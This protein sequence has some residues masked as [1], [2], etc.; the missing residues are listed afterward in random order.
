MNVATAMLPREEERNRLEALVKARRGAEKEQLRRMTAC[1]GDE[2]KNA[3]DDDEL[4]V[5]AA[6]ALRGAI[7][8]LLLQEEKAREA[9]MMLLI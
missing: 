1:A 8:I 2:G 6:A 9:L 4:I 7:I 5:V 3:L